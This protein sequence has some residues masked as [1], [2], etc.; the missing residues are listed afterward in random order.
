MMKKTWEEFLRNKKFRNKLALGILVLVLLVA[1]LPYYFAFIE[2]RKGIVINDLLLDYIDSVN[3]SIPTFIIIWSLSL[4][5]LYINLKS[6]VRLLQMLW[7]FNVLSLSR[8]LSIYLV[9][10]EPPA[11]LIELIDPITNTIYGARFITKDL[12]F[13]GHTATLVTFALCMQKKLHKV[14]VFSGAIA[15]GI[16]VL[17]QHVHYTIDVIA[18]FIFPFFLVPIA[19]RICKPFI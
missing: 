16:L 17:I 18:A 14:I 5:S 9:P 7:A 2:A 12:F 19:K 11:D 6:P 15:V 4:W 8:I 10:L 13:S 3:V 1:F